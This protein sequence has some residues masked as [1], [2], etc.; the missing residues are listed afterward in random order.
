MV[1]HNFHLLSIDLTHFTFRVRVSKRKLRTRNF[2]A[3]LVGKQV[4]YSAIHQ[5]N[6]IA[7]LFFYDDT[8]TTLKKIFLILQNFL[9]TISTYSIKSVKRNPRLYVRKHNYFLLIDIIYK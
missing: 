6:C 5:Y 7:Y 2:H 9:P 1:H 3:N 8:K 4:L